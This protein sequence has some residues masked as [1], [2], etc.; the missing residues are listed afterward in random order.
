[1]QSATEVSVSVNH[2]NN[3]MISKDTSPKLTSSAS[4]AGSDLSPGENGDSSSSNGHHSHDNG[5]NDG[6]KDSGVDSNGGAED[7]G[8]G[9]DSGKQ[10]SS[11]SSLTSGA[12][13]FTPIGAAQSDAFASDP[14]KSAFIPQ[15]ND[16]LHVEFTPSNHHQHQAQP[17]QHQQLMQPVYD[18][19]D[20]MKFSNGG[21]ATPDYSTGFRHNGM[22]PVPPQHQQQQQ[23]QQPGGGG[24][25]GWGMED[26]NGINY[27]QPPPGPPNHNLM[28]SAGGMP[29]Q[30]P[31]HMN[32]RPVQG[33]GGQW[34]QGMQGGHRQQS[35]QPQQNQYMMNQQ[36][37]GYNPQQ[38]AM[39]GWSQSQNSWSTA[40]M[41]PAMGMNHGGGW[42][43]GGGG[44]GGG[45]SRGGMGQRNRGFNSYQGGGMM[46][47]GGYMGHRGG[48]RRHNFPNAKIDLGGGD[49]QVR[50]Q[51][52]FFYFFLSKLGSN[53]TLSSPCFFSGS[54]RLNA[55]SGTVLARRQQ[56]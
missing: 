36:Q 19:N 9:D 50:G 1:M 43:G 23:Q 2:N 46:G 12:S 47:G 33:G 49:D 11:S 3:T 20:M 10:T 28:M 22:T 53:F 7:S 4:A 24:H 52:V 42:G 31:P 18:S 35:Y 44:R 17:Q 32:R 39:G 15:K 5:K 21:A 38:G 16:G 6:G 25:S 51:Y 13:T 26:L 37:R 14:S 41:P 45:G 40:G 55:Q 54:A 56:R 48:G 8:A 27:G 30:M 34:H 29:P